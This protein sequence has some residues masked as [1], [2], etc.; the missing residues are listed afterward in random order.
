MR[1]KM[2][3]IKIFLIKNDLEVISEYGKEAAK[4][5]LK[6]VVAKESLK[7][8]TIFGIDIVGSIWLY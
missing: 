8:V 5:K 6:D 2:D 1:E 7:L 3:A 4:S